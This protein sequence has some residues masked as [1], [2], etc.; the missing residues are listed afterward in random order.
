[1]DPQEVTFNVTGQTLVFDCPEGRPSSV[2]SVA[3]HENFD[4]DDAT[5]ETATTGAASVETNPNTTFAAAGG[6]S[7][8]DPKAIAVTAATGITRGRKYMVENASDETETVE[9]ASIASTAVRTRTPLR[10]DYATT[11]GLFYS[12]RISIGV[13]STWVADSNN[14]SADGD[15][16]ARYRVRWEYV[17]GGVTYVRATYFDLVRYAAKYTVSGSDID[18]MFPG[19]LDSLPIDDQEDEGARVIKSAWREVKMDLHAHGKAAMSARNQSVI[20]ILI[21]YKAN[22]VARRSSMSTGAA[23]TRDMFAVVVEEYERTFNR[24]ITQPK[25]PFSNDS[26]G[27]GKPAQ[28]LPLWRK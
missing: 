10:N 26:G 7:Q 17:V 19:W 2:T 11:T 21:A 13:N 5:A 9:V 1:M 3:V 8:S 23:I 6:V 25:I 20:D 14:I 24:L 15:P 18:A 16:N 22:V 12:T 27:G 4:G 28:R